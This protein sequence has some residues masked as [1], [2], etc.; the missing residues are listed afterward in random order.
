[1]RLGLAGMAIVIPLFALPF[2]S[3]G[4]EIKPNSATD[5]QHTYSGNPTILTVSSFCFHSG[6]EFGGNTGISAVR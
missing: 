3:Y 1:M 5:Q 2:Q 6:L 4:E